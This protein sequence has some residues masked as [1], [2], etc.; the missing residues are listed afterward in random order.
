M[1]AIVL[2]GRNDLAL[3]DIEQPHCGSD[4]V[5]VRVTNSGICGTDL[6]IYDG[7]IP[8]HYPL[9]MGHEI[10]GEVV[11]GGDG[12]VR[13][14][15]RVVIDPCLFC[16]LC[17][18]CRVGQTNL[19]P[20][21]G[22]I[23]RDSNG[24]FTEYFP[25]PLTHVYRLPKE[26]GS[27]SGPLIQVLTTCVHA[28]RFLSI[29][30]GQSVVVIGLGVAGQ[31]HLQLAK[32]RGANPV[33][34]VTRNRWK[35]QLAKDLGADLTLSSGS[36]ALRTVLECTNGHGADVVIV[37]TGALPAIASAISMCRLGATLSLFGVSTTA[38][39]ELPY[40]L[41]YYK[42]LKIFSS[43]AATAQDFPAAI[44][45]VARGVVRLDPLVTHRVSL[46]QLLS[47]IHLL[48]GDSDHRMKVIVEHG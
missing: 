15:D 16:G 6:K 31:L 9:V 1:K 38:E 46:A 14:G 7:S 37:A 11:C 27:E 10:S 17:T 13:V 23:G 48:E 44:D 3:E 33:I 5:L 22:L 42:E 41:L 36:D 45:L 29:F 2:R 28:Q 21:G 30:P 20:N 24:G 4:Q 34:G 35:G 32:A 40:Y 12:N 47:A 19:C 25:A 26:I 18:N 8:V 39:Y 43:R